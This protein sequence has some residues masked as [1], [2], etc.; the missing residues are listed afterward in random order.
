MEQRHRVAPN[1]SVGLDLGPQAFRADS[2]ARAADFL[3]DG[4]VHGC[5]FDPHRGP[6]DRQRVD[7]LPQRLEESSPSVMRS[8]TPARRSFD[9]MARR[10]LPGSGVE[11]RQKITESA[12]ASMNGRPSEGVGRHE[13]D[14]EG[15]AAVTPER[16]HHVRKK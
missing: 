11:S 4:R 6:D 3:R 13:V 7:V 16:L 10:T 15:N 1:A 5:A 8:D 2:G 14:L 12:P 9:L